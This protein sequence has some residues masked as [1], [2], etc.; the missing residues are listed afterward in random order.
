MRIVPRL[1]LGGLLGLSCIIIIGCGSPSKP[2]TVPAK[3]KVMYQKTTPA[4][5]ALVVFHPADPEVEKRIGGKPFAK[6]NDDGTFTLTTY[7]EGDGAPPGDYGVTID[8]QVPVKQGKLTL[9]IGESSPTQVKLN[10][11][12]TNPQQP[13]FRETVKK[14]GP[15]EFNFEVD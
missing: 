7:E 8:W 14:E 15:N 13:A 2:A 6:V 9:R 11:R 3:G 4:A 12:Y 1:A 10:P 5:G